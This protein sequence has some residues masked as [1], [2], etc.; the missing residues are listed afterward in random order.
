MNDTEALPGNWALGMYRIIYWDGHPLEQLEEHVPGWEDILDRTL[1][2]VLRIVAALEAAM[3][4]TDNF[5]PLANSLVV[6]ALRREYPNLTIKD[7]QTLAGR[8]MKY[9]LT[10]TPGEGGE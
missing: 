7:A 6:G 9:W 2:E 8:F 3:D 10:R 5:T 1:K 4:V